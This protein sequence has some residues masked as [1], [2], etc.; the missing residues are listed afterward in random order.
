MADSDR[1]LYVVLASISCPQER[2]KCLRCSTLDC[3][4][5]ENSDH[6]WTRQTSR[7]GAPKKC[8]QCVD[9]GGYEIAVSS[10]APCEHSKVADSFD[11]MLQVRTTL[12]SSE[13]PVHVPKRRAIDILVTL[14]LV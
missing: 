12:P 9:H 3:G 14:L 1:K 13:V 7:G 10:V 2:W 4:A 5:V 11:A 6:A 8:L